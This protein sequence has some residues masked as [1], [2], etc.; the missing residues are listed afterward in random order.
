MQPTS[1]SSP[2]TTPVTCADTQD[3]T[4][5]TT[6]SRSPAAAPTTEA[7]K[8]PRT[9]RFPA[10]PA[11]SNATESRA[12]SSSHQSSGEAAHSTG[13]GNH[14]EAIEAGVLKNVGE[15]RKGHTAVHQALMPLPIITRKASKVGVP[16]WPAKAGKTFPT[17]SGQDVCAAIPETATLKSEQVI[18]PTSSTRPT[19]PLSA[20]DPD[21]EPKAH[22]PG[23]AKTASAVEQTSPTADASVPSTEP[24]GAKVN[25]V[26]TCRGC[27]GREPLVKDGK[28]RDCLDLA[29]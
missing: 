17:T 11:A 3:Q 8:H 29:A 24:T 1:A 14:V 4:P 7:T 12:T 18:M 6:S 5:S 28:C 15:G 22:Q 19:S 26:G 27:G 23:E 13:S 16:Q 20:T 25:R 21:P 9:T 2:P 10:R